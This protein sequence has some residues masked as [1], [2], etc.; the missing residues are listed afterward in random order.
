M[1]SVAFPH[2]SQDWH[3]PDWLNEQ[4]LQKVRKFH[5]SFPKYNKT[6]LHDLKNLANF[7]GIKKFFVKDESYRLGLNA[8]KVL[9]GSYA[10]GNYLARKLGMSIDDLPYEH[11][12]SEEICRQLGD[13]TFITATDG[14][15][16]RGVAWTANKLKQH[17][18]VYMPK[19]T[20]EER[21]VNIKKEGA[22][23]SITEFNYDDAVRKAAKEARENDW[24]LVQD[25]SWDGYE[26]IPR[27]IIQGY[28]TMVLEAYEQLPVKPTHVFLQAGVG[29]MAAAVSGFFA[30]VYPGK[31]KP[32]IVIVEPEQADCIFRTA[33]AADGTIHVVGGDMSTI[34]A[35][36]ACGEPCSIGWDILSGAADYAVRCDDSV[37][38]K[39]MRILG[40]PLDDDAR[41]ISGESGAVTSGLVSALLLDVRYEKIKES[42]HLT[43]DSVVLC[44][45]TEGATDL[46]NYRRVVW[47]GKYAGV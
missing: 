34:M 30:N 38:A 46:E 43:S 2:K 23:A 36:L 31:D 29:S 37:A 4:A 16:G 35:G 7:M 20:S 25:T 40:A 39:G 44:F 42:L 26:D 28:G 18:I 47:D 15:H 3:A 32:I 6:P 10:I 41:I 21:L 14:N 45:S 1:Q 8:F 5:A 17:A 12:I 27:W 13:I 24:V 11:L 33:E 19:G 9:G 22:E